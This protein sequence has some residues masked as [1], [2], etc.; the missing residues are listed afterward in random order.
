MTG[1]HLLLYRLAELML[2]FEQHILPVDLLFDDE[3][4]GDFVK[5][6]QIDSP[7]QQMLLD[8]VLTESVREEKLYVSFT[9]EGYF[10]FVLGEVIYNRTE[11]L[12][13][14]ALK[15][16]VEENKLNGIKEGVE[17]CLIR[18]V[19]KDDLTRLIWLIDYGAEFL[20]LAVVPLAASFMN[21]HLE[22]SHKTSIE[23]A[24]FKHVRNVLRHVYSTPSINDDLILFKCIDYLKSKYCSVLLD[25]VQC[26]L[27]IIVQRTY[28]DENI[29]VLLKL[30]PWIRDKKQKA[31]YAEL[32]V[33]LSSNKR[34]SKYIKWEINSTLA[35]YLK[36]ISNFSKAI[37]YHRKVMKYELE[38]IGK[39]SAEYAESIY[40]SGSVEIISGRYK[41]ARKLFQ[42]ELKIREI[43]SRDLNFDV[44]ISR[45]FHSIALTFHYEG[46]YRKAIKNY[47]IALERRLNE[48]GRYCEATI[49]TLANMG[50]SFYEAGI[51]LAESYL[52][53]AHR[54]GKLLKGNYSD[55]ST[56]LP[57]LSRIK[58]AKGEADAAEEL[59][60]INLVNRE[61]IFG[62]SSREV[63]FSHADL[64]NFYNETGFFNKALEHAQEQN[65]IL[66]RVLSNN[67]DYSISSYEE[68]GS[69]YYHLEMY[70]NA[71]D[72]FGIA[73]FLSK[74]YF[75]H[76]LK[77]QQEMKYNK[78]LC[79]LNIG[80]YLKARI[81]FMDCLRFESNGL[82]L[83]LIGLSLSQINPA[84]SIKYHLRAL[85]E[86]KCEMSV[87]QLKEIEILNSVGNNSFSQVKDIYL[88]KLK[89]KNLPNWL[90]KA[91][92]L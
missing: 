88:S 45:C 17:Q 11:G 3:K 46:N 68:L 32:L 23:Q 86:Y 92:D 52:E 25:A 13:A 74:K 54:I 7:Y 49:V 4:I 35:F 9:V 37:I 39:T 50:I 44:F 70:K 18:D 15:L 30:F 89:I 14:E 8:G 26:S 16:I 41:E 87:Y 77:F 84:L 43:I 19:Q 91:Y 42:K 73:L 31:I 66:V 61:F 6:I 90:Q 34:L 76:N 69:V 56:I 33:N 82:L 64:M 2:D 63:A 71:I 51:S 75:K 24:I 29:L 28:S 79:Y 1:N 59:L 38:E 55:S 10:H 57:Y 67:H 83:N 60:K 20:D 85:E 58:L 78:G 72:S 22:P 36:N 81:L 21:F 40:F 65:R 5:S 27:D 62:S 48:G 53:D 47:E 80:D 12:G